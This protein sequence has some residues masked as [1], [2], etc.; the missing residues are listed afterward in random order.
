[1]RYTRRDFLK[2]S[3]L[4]GAALI[5]R[6]KVPPPIRALR[7]LAPSRSLPTAT[8]WEFSQATGVQVISEQLP[9]NSN[10]ELVISNYD[11]VL[12]P[13]HI[14]TLFIRNNLVRELNQL[15]ITNYQQRPYDPLNSFSVLASRG[16]IGINARTIQPPQTWKEF[17]ALA[18]TVPTYLPAQES[19][20]AAIKSLGESINT[21]NTYFHEKAQSLI[22]NLQ[23]S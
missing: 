14:L 13:S 6:S 3:G 17:F 16:V 4:G 10:W 18:R 12:A 20:N 7:I 19:L 22:S 2:L 21:R 8:M 15:P 5:L 11:I 23:S 1:M 9:V